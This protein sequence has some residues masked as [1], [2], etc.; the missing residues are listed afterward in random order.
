MEANRRCAKMALTINSQQEEYLIYLVEK[1]ML[2]RYGEGLDGPNGP[3]IENYIANEVKPR[4]KEE[5]RVITKSGFTDYFLIVGDFM[6]WCRDNGIPTGPARG[7]AGG[8]AVAYCLYITD[9]EPLEHELIF[10]RFLNDERLSMPDIDMDIDWWRRQEALEYLFK[11]YGEDRV[12]QII[13]FGTLSAKALIDDLGRVFGIPQ[14]DLK[15]LKAHVPDVVE[16]K[17]SDDKNIRYVDLMENQAFVDKLHEIGEKE[18][19]FIPALARLEGLHRHGSV[20][21]G[22]VIIA[23][24]PMNNLAP[25][26]QPPKAKRAVLQ[27]EMMDAEAVGLLKI[28][29]LGLRTVTHI[30][31]AEKDVRRLYDPNFYTRKL[32]L[33]IQEAYDIINAGDTYGIFQ[34]EGTGITRFAQQLRVDNFNDITA[35][36]A[37]YRPGPLD[38]GMANEYI[39][40]K[41]GRAPV[42]YVHPDLE[43]ILNKT[44]G[45]IIYQEQVMFIAQRI[46]GFSLGE[47]DVLRSAMG[48]KDKRKMTKE[49]DKFRK[50]AEA[51]GYDKATIDVLVEQI[52]TFARYGFNKSHAVA[53]G[54][55]TYWTAVLKAKYPVAFFNAW[56]N[57]TDAGEKKGWIM[58]QAQR[59]GIDILPPDINQSGAMFTAVDTKTIRFGLSAVKGMGASFVA[60]TLA[61]RENRG[62][63]QSYY[64]YC[65]R[66]TSIPVDKKEALV[67]AGAF[68]FEEKNSPDMHRATLFAN[69]RSINEQAKKKSAVLE[70]T[71]QPRMKP[72]ELAEL[73]KEYAN[74]Y[75]TADPIKDIQQEILMMGGTVGVPVTEL[76]GE[77][78]I[79]GRITNV[80]VLTTKKGDPMCFL[81]VD[82]GIVQHSVTI[83]PNVWKR[84]APHMVK[85]SYT[86]IRCEIGRF[87]GQPALQAVAVFPVDLKNRESDIILDLG[88]PTGLTLA[89]VKMT[90]DSAESGTSAVYIRMRHKRHIFTLKS[91][92]YR[93]K[94]TDDILM[95]LKG[96]LGEGAIALDRR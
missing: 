80:H 39:E 32:P 87:R 90:L 16:D 61:D 10:E 8:S 96:I 1:G 44:Y 69:A 43:P 21:A 29:A 71:R 17:V 76:R 84:V 28:D 60:K 48:K 33:D 91:D 75:I 63:Y 14:K 27:Y 86:A 3:Y 92:S 52:E 35:L 62:P 24:E 20:H 66:M 50:G 36:L 85:D 74:F 58:D 68:D 6:R 19:R 54:F 42:T 15:E 82:D 56:L 12:S 94:V 13:T 23:S 77:P 37:L 93:I 9:V 64:D 45:I 95:K 25:T 78:V 83:F 53:Y 57:I 34:L 51:R 49:I 31:W 38:S 55:L 11:K 88:E 18:P 46:A 30:D 40:R 65:R 2:E 89:M 7:S 47:A 22:G 72:L 67:G 79:G 5:L 4:L 41:H 70:Y 81:D 26:Y 59:R 73:E